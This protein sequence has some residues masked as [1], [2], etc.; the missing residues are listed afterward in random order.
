[1]APA[2]A[3]KGIKILPQL[4]AAEILPISQKRKNRG[5]TRGTKDQRTKNQRT[6]SSV[7]H[8]RVTVG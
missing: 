4:P 3:G 2:L 1:M 5:R 7:A 6:K 8:S